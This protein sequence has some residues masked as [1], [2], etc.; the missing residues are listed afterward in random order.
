MANPAEQL[1][2]QEAPCQVCSYHR[3]IVFD[4]GKNMYGLPGGTVLCTICLRQHEHWMI[5]N[6]VYTGEA[7]TTEPQELHAIGI[8]EH[9]RRIFT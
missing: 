4:R 9:W 8:Q 2:D 3:G 5:E 1:Y 7:R 6:G